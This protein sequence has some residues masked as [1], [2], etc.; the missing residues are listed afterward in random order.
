[1][2]H[3][4]LIVVDAY[5]KWVESVLMTSIT[6]EAV[7][8]ALRRMFAIH[9]IPDVL[10]SDNGPQLS[11]ATFQLFLASQGIR[12]AQ[13]AP[14]YQ[15]GNGMAERAVRSV[16]EAF[17]RLGPGGWH[18]R[19]STCLLSQHSTPCPSTNRSLAEM[20]MGRRLRTTLDRLHPN[21]SSEATS[22]RPKPSRTFIEGSL[23]YV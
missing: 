22:D 21:Y 13:V 15:A 17:A 1:M 8:Q 9:G 2:E 10:V 23:V 6:S 19:V 14:F 20:L 16:K 18:E 3:T 4:F 12:H 7:I 11:S 5:S